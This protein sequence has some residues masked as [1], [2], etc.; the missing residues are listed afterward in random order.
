MESIK[1]VMFRVKQNKLCDLTS[2]KR[3]GTVNDGSLIH[4]CDGQRHS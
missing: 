4:Y 3:L 1:I 2:N